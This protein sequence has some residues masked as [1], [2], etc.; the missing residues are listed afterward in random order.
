MEYSINLGETFLKFF[1]DMG[2]AT[3]SWQQI[4][5]IAV[6]CLLIYLAIVKQY[7]PLL[8]LPI[9][10]GMLLANLPLTGITQEGGLLYYLSK[11]VKLGIFPP[12]IFLGVGCMTDFGPLI[13][14]PKSLLLGAAAQLGIFIAFIGAMLLGSAVQTVLPLYS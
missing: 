1:R 13:A 9:A 8:L 7:E 3:I 10:F 4:V 5:M 2:F 14:N 6:A 12:L 11:G